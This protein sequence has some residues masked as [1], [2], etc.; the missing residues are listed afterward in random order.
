MTCHEARDLYSAMLDEA[1]DA[2]ERAAVEAHVAGCAECARELERFR[3]TVSLVRAAGSVR[4]PVG[5]VDRVLAAARPTPWYRR[6]ARWRFWPLRVKIPLQ[7]A[8]VVLVSGAA[9]YVF[10]HTPEL[11]QAARQ[12]APVAAPTPTPPVTPVPPALPGNRGA[13]ATMPG[14][15]G[16]PATAAGVGSVEPA[17]RAAERAGPAAPPSPGAKLAQPPAEPG[18][19]A[20]ADAARSVAKRLEDGAGK[21]SEPTALARQNKEAE[22]RA[23]PES[24][25]SGGARVERRAEPTAPQAA[26]QAT[27]D[28]VLPSVLSD[29][30]P[31]RE[32]GASTR[33]EKAKAP[34]AAPPPAGPADG[35]L[36]GPSRARQDAMTPLTSPAS[37]DVAAR[38]AA[39]DPA[40]ALRGLSDLL[41]R[42]GGREVGRRADGD[43]AAIDVVV[44]RER[45]AEFVR[46]LAQLGRLSLERE[47]ATLPGLVRV[48][49]RIGG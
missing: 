32:P 16:A 39:A 15:P 12:E 1:L 27:R 48:A 2:G 36:Q 3:R 49:L 6:L 30:P 33:E 7:A 13:P 38:L 28:R 45:Y 29:A 44:P 11:Q 26:D 24:P 47:A 42:A 31:A 17:K 18:E 40:L 35:R 41:E 23:E 4:A 25:A 37:A 10:Q 19:T 21:T 14:P 9:V 20:S 22:R 46:G 5:F 8:A 43:T 34:A